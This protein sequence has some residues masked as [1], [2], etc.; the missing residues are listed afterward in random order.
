MNKAGGR[1][2]CVGVGVGGAFLDF[3]CF[4]ELF[5][6]PNHRW[7][8]GCVPKT[9]PPAFCWTF[10]TI[11]GSKHRGVDS[12]PGQA[13]WLS[14]MGSSAQS[15]RWRWR[16]CLFPVLC[17]FYLMI[18]HG[19]LKQFPCFKD[20]T[21]VDLKIDGAEP[22]VCGELQEHLW[23]CEHVHAWFYQTCGMSCYN[24]ATRIFDVFCCCRK[25]G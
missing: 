18:W 21:L 14:M 5:S 15:R 4:Q 1:G 20:Q 11:L 17:V 13:S 16:W 19:F 8:C 10:G 22:L 24:G 23:A 12:L 9:L 3:N 6:S 7:Y 2:L 25:N